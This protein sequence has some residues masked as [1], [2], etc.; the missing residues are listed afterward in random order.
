MKKILLCTC[1]VLFALSI[2]FAQKKAVATKAA[3]K[4]KPIIFAVTN[5][6]KTLEPIGEFD[7]GELVATTGGDADPK[8][9]TNFTANYYKPKTSYK[10]VFGGGADGTV[11]IRS[12]NPKSECAKNLADVT[13]ISGKAKLKGLVMGLATNEAVSKSAP[14]LRRMPTADERMEIE[15]LVRAEY[16]KQKVSA[17]ALKNLH[18]HNLT[19]I[20][21]DNDGKPEMVGSYWVESAP[22]ERS[23]LFFIAD[24]DSSGKY[25]FGYSE[26]QKMTQKE[27]MG[28]ADI[29]ALDTGIYS[30]LLLDSF[31]Y[32]SD[33][34]AKIFT[35][36]QGLEGNGSNVYARKDG[37][38]TKV[39]NS[40]NYHC[41]F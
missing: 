4:A 29:K 24:K 34:T 32:G 3:A 6:G 38:W 17:A 14:G 12:S 28:G 10:L 31:A 8:D 23:L 11:T 2:A 25:S 40:S 18:Y 35:F 1:L 41:A 37:K 30:E 36:I 7:K 15:A 33:S 9:L 13:T 5:D 39:F 27:M 21:V 22:Q 26:Y 19:A 20:D 16:A